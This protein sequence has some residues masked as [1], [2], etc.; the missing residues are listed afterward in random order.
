MPTVLLAGAFGQRNPGDDAL[1]SAF[2]AAL[3]NWRTVAPTGN[4]AALTDRATGVQPVPNTAIG[5]ARALHACDAVVFAG[6]TVFK[7]LDPSTGRRPHAL[8]TRALLLARSA[9]GLRRPVALVGVGAGRLPDRTAQRLA[10]ALAATAD[11][12]VLRDDASADVLA[13]AGVPQPMRIG[14]DVAWTLFGDPPPVRPA[15]P[16]PL[17]VTVSRHAG[18]AAATA[19]LAAG[20]A[21]ALADRPE[22]T[23]VLLEPWQVG[24][25]GLDDLD[26]ARHLQRGL[27]V[28]T[29]RPVTVCTPPASVPAAALRYRDARLVF[30]QRFHSLVAAAAAGTPFVASAHEPKLAEL[31]ARLGQQA[32]APDGPIAALA[33]ALDEAL[34]GPAPDVAEMATLTERAAASL[35]LLRTLLDGGR[36]GYPPDLHVLRLHPEA[37]VR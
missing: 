19:G 24:G 11:M 6:G 36:S 23:H 5:T 20:I 3:P 16:G 1:L 22:L 30:G 13:A 34:D 31:A 28:A 18:G 12:T 9:R 7:V 17:V 21:Q 14:A 35:A 2:A 33:P 25:P 26:L 8:L 10:R 27:H 32:V 4:A 15:E 37:V 29:D